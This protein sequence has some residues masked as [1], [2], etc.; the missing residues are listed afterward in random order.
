VL[1]DYQGIWGES[2]KIQGEFLHEDASQCYEGGSKEFKV[3]ALFDA[4]IKEDERHS[5]AV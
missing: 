3:F 4:D 2:T 5:M 1:L